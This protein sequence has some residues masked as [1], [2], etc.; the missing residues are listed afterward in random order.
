MITIA[1]HMYDMAPCIRDG[2]LICDITRSAYYNRH[3]IIYIV[4]LEFYQISLHA[5]GN[6]VEYMF[7]KYECSIKLAIER[8][9]NE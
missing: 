6:N 9:M 7:Y 4:T 2:N 3:N 8:D 1:K 5:N